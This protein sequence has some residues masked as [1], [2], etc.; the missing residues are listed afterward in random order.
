MDLLMELSCCKV[1][2]NNS[3]DILSNIC[4]FFAYNRF[5]MSPF[6]GPT[7]LTNLNFTRFT[8]THVFIKTPFPICYT[9]K[10]C[11]IMAFDMLIGSLL[12]LTIDSST[13]MI[14]CW[15]LII[16][17]FGNLVEFH[18]IRKR[19]IED[20][21]LCLFFFCDLKMEHMNR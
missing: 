3:R 2:I 8:A 4:T 17:G 21:L 15:A 13:Q 7:I 10:T 9:M 18:R 20:L 11:W 6:K 19:K 12:A 1:F 5:I 14:A 16:F